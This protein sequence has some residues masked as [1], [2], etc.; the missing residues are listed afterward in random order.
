M[1]PN[2]CE[3]T[4]LQFETRVNALIPTAV[5]VS[6][7]YARVTVASHTEADGTSHAAVI[8]KCEAFE[9]LRLETKSDSLFASPAVALLSESGEQIGYLESQLASGTARNC[10]R[11]IAI[12]REK[13][14]HPVTG[15]IIGAVVYMI[16]LTEP[17][18]RERSRKMAREQLARVQ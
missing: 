4:N 10:A 3:V 2:S 7:F 12:F 13:R 6:A 11:W 9:V 8:E 5:R 1:L 15:A 16:Y 14:R 18:A 17:F